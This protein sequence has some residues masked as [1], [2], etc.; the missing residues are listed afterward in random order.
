MAASRGTAAAAMLRDRQARPCRHVVARA[1]QENLAIAVCSDCSVD[2]GIT[3]L[4]CG[5]GPCRRTL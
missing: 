4:S 1:T 2:A 5:S 3:T